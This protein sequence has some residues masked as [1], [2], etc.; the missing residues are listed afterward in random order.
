MLAVHGY[1]GAFNESYQ[2]R[3]DGTSRLR[4]N[5]SRMDPDAVMDEHTRFAHSQMASKWDFELSEE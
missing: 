1:A 4:L 3:T 5:D 2:E